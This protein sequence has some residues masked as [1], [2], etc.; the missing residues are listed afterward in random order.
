MLHGIYVGDD[1]TIIGELYT[2]RASA[3]AHNL[4][5]QEQIPVLLSP[6]WASRKAGAYDIDTV[7]VANEVM[8]PHLEGICIATNF[9]NRDLRNDIDDSR[10][11]SCVHSLPFLV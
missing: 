11:S 3:V 8:I 4:Q 2:S 6:M 7:V 5:T 10:F 9:I 1:L